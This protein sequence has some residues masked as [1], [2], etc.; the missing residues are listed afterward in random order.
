[1]VPKAV[2]SH[3]PAQSLGMRFGYTRWAPAAHWPSMKFR[4]H[5]ERS[6]KEVERA[7]QVSTVK[8]G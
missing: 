3:C 1:M 8:E 4:L 5:W 2:V 6:G 7:S